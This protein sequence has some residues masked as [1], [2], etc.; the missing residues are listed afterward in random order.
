MD[1]CKTIEDSHVRNANL[2]KNGASNLK[3]N[4]ASSMNPVD[5]I[6]L[7]RSAAYPITD[8]AGDIVRHREIAGFSLTE[9]IY[10]SELVLS[11][12]CHA[13]AY[14]SFVLEG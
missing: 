11:A 6:S 4:G 5:S 3:Y 2:S 1:L 12:H 13:Q 14:L 7:N 9:R 10:P 8:A